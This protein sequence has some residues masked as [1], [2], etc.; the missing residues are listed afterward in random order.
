MEFS[1]LGEIRNET[2][3][4]EE[5]HFK[6]IARSIVPGESCFSPKVAAIL[7]GD[8]SRLAAIRDEMSSVH[9]NGFL[10][11]E[12][13][14]HLV[15]E[16]ILWMTDARQTTNHER[17]VSARIAVIARQSRTYIEDHLHEPIRAVDLSVFSG[18]SLR[19]LE[20]CFAAH[21]QISPVA[22]IKAR[23][24]NA[25]RRDLASANPSNESVAG[26]ARRNGF[27]QL[28][29]FSVEYRAHFGESPSQTLAASNAQS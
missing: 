3:F 16:T 22:Y 18:V 7:Q 8:P 21:F 6:S 1:T 5:A 20:R 29:R 10:D 24:L 23:R 2:L 4:L 9:E 14:S 15:A 12:T 11:P 26:V 17:L 13:A 28:G 19:T 27:S 25:A